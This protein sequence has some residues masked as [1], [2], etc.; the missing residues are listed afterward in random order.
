LT[1]L[2]RLPFKVALLIGQSDEQLVHW[3][4]APRL[5]RGVHWWQ[6]QELACQLPIAAKEGSWGA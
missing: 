4:F 5:R 6:N 2:R 3:Q 1:G